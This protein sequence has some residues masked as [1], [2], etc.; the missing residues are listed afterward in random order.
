MVWYSCICLPRNQPARSSH[1]RSQRLS[2]EEDVVNEH[3]KVELLH[4]LICWGIYFIITELITS[5]S[6]V[7]VAGADGLGK[8]GADHGGEL[9]TVR[10]PHDEQRAAIEVGK[11]PGGQ[12]L[13][14]LSGVGDCLHV[15]CREPAPVVG[16]AVAHTHRVVLHAP[17]L[18]KIYPSA[19]SIDH[20]R[21]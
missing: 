12:G 16:V 19:R 5:E 6:E 8:R 10:L 1:S 15:C 14:K 17:L 7:D 13:D 4:M 3:T 18:S 20:I 2:V 9:A 11:N 21:I